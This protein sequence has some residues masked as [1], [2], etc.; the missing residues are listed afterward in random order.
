MRQ[1]RAKIKIGIKFKIK[2]N[3]GIYIVNR[4]IRYIQFLQMDIRCT[5]YVG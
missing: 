1:V 2:S 5:D 3:G 4:L